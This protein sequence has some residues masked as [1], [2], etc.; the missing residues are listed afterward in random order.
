MM[1]SSEFRTEYQRRILNRGK[2]DR[3]DSHLKGITPEQAAAQ[4]CGIALDSEREGR[5]ELER[6][7]FRRG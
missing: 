2:P 3:A 4:Y 6:Y 1:S 7:R 5:A